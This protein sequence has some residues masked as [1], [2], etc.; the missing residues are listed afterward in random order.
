MPRFRPFKELPSSIVYMGFLEPIIQFP[1]SFA[2]CLGGSPPFLYARCVVYVSIW[3]KNKLTSA[4]DKHAVHSV[5]GLDNCCNP[6]RLRKKNP[7][8]LFITTRGS[9]HS[10]PP[11]KTTFFGGVQ[12]YTW[13]HPQKKMR[14]K[15]QQ[16]DNHSPSLDKFR[17][18]VFGSRFPYLNKTHLI[19]ESYEGSLAGF[20]VI[21]HLPRLN[22]IT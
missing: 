8:C 13:R 10:P 3:E 16:N 21:S 9:Q 6:S 12:S 5:F 19:Y 14:N 18:L 15:K 17:L 2:W 7:A 20:I 11:K 1:T 22:R 4:V